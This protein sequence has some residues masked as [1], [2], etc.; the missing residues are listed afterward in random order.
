MATKKARV[1]HTTGKSLVH[2]PKGKRH[3]ARST[4]TVES[5]KKRLRSDAPKG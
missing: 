5:S 2:F 1:L 4:G 3:G